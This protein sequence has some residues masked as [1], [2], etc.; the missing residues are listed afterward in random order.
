MDA[1]PDIYSKWNGIR[2]RESIKTAIS[3]VVLAAL[4]SVFLLVKWVVLG[5]Q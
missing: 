3:L 2:S 1:L 5:G 4:A